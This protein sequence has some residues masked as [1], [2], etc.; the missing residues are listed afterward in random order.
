[1]WNPLLCTGDSV[2]VWVPGSEFQALAVS[3]LPRPRKFPA[4]PP[5]LPKKVAGCPQFCKR[6]LIPC[7]DFQMSQGPMNWF[8]TLAVEWRKN[9]KAKMLLLTRSLW[10]TL[11]WTR[12]STYTVAR[13]TGTLTHTHTHSHVPE[14]P[15]VPQDTTWGE[16]SEQYLTYVGGSWPGGR[17]SPGALAAV[18]NQLWV[19]P[20]QHSRR[21]SGNLWRKHCFYPEGSQKERAHYREKRI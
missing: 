11:L 1:M 12:P 3:T 7:F 16:F 15:Q 10:L 6:P 13:I 14:H 2:L 4:F 9:F 17:G 8:I 21:G 20:P 18:I 19:L 5:S